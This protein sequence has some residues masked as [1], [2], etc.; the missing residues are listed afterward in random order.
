[1]ISK[2][3]VFVLIIIFLTCF[4]AFSNP[5]GTEPV[6]LVLSGGGARGAYQI[7]VWKAL[8]D[9]E[10]EIGG[11]FGVSVGAI[12]GAMIASDDFDLAKKLWMK[13]EKSNVMEISEAGQRVLSGNFSFNDLAEASVEFYKD[14]G[15]NV[16]PLENLLSKYIDEEKIRTGERD[17]GMIAYSLT[18]FSEKL[19]YLDDIPDGQLVDYILA[20]ANFPAFQRKVIDG[21]EFIDGGVY[22]NL[23]VEMID[24]GKYSRAVLVSLDIYMIEDLVDYILDYSNYDLDIIN[25][26]PGSDPGSVLDFSPEN[27]IKLMKMG[28]LDCLKAFGE[29]H[30][31][32]YYLYGNEPIRELFLSLDIADRYEAAALLEIKVLRGFSYFSSELSYS[33]FIL[34]ELLAAAASEIE[35][36]EKYAEFYGIEKQR[37]YSAEDL[38]REAANKY[39]HRMNNGIYYNRYLDFLSYLCLKAK[40]CSQPNEIS[41][42]RYLK[43]YAGFEEN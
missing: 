24:T 14:G 25:I 12:N 5:S 21:E 11:I 17:F 37:F 18:D 16:A 3:P 40:V 27:S 41:M 42:E 35:L 31:D 20:S 9:L 29:L 30:G 28:Y 8:N 7:G 13:L 39:I 15:I 10:I 6:A 38:L 33:R 4:S 34:P 32:K 19:M 22:K 43:S 2:F 36:I 26:H 1:M 23:A